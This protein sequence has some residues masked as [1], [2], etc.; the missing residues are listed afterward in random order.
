V[1]N[2]FLGE[3]RMFGGNFAPRGWAMCSGQILPIAQND[4]LYALIG[5]TYGGDGQVTF[6]LPDLR[7]R[8]PIHQGQGIG[9]SSYTLGQSGGIEEVTLLSSQL[10]AHTHPIRAVSTAATANSP[11]GNTWAAWSDDPYT[12][13]PPNGQLAPSAISSAG[14]SIPHENLSPILVVTFI[15]ALAGIFP[16]Q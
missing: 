1:S 8:R 13:G 15:I 2:A 7:G 4:A 6:G 5:T 10:P 11:Q 16:S 3:I 9:L 14:S 12:G